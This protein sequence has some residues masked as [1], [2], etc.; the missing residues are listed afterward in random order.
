V[1]KFIWNTHSGYLLS[2]VDELESGMIARL[3]LAGS[4]CN[5]FGTDIHDLTVQVTY[6]SKTRY[7]GCLPSFPNAHFVI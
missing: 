6:E 2:E 4:A 7:V 3:M 1:L 5:A